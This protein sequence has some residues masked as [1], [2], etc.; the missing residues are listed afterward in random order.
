MP[1][2]SLCIVPH[3]MR[4]VSER[5]RIIGVLSIVL[6]SCVVLG[7]ICGC[8]QLDG[9]NRTRQGNRLFRETQFIDAAAEYQR[10][11]K[12]V[13]DPVIHYNLGLAYS[14]I[15]KPGFDGPIL[16]GTQSDPVCT[17]IPG[18]KMVQAGACVKEGDRHF[19]ECGASKT[20]PIQKQIAE[21]EEK[22]KTEADDAKKKDLESQIRDKQNELGRYICASSF[23]CVEG[24]FCSLRSP[25]IAD[26][27]A[28]HFQGWLKV[29]MGD[30]EIKREQVEADRELEAAKQTGN[31]SQISA[32][33]KRVD[34]L[35]TK[36]QT[37]KIMTKLWSDSEQYD[38][39]IA[40]WESLLPE[41]PNDPEIMYNLA[42]INLSAG[43]WRKAVEWHGKV[44][45]ATKDPSGKVAEYQFIG[46]I[47]WGK[48][49]ARSLIGVD[50]IELADRGLGALQKAAEL[51]P[52]NYKL[53]SLQASLF[54]FR[55]TVHGTSWAAG[56]ER[57]SAQDL[58][59]LTRVLVDKA[60]KAQ[61]GQAPGAPP[62]PTPPVPPTPPA[63]PAS[64]ATGP[65][66]GPATGPATGP[67][68]GGKAEKSGG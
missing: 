21:L 24:M 65:T 55:A 19:A 45:E 54:N 49:N 29:Q 3:A 1:S 60:T 5:S 2:T 52:E 22:R 64:S 66:T 15:F 6:A 41:R 9:R 28:Q 25:E 11:L 36:D 37:R 10:A 57:A 62:A 32:A 34:D 7:G 59:Q 30:D 42:G 53:T 26:L 23:K 47:A 61:Q 8:E 67:T 18:A 58:S 51:Q 43:N 13:D 31:N 56:I 33:Q 35:G 68:M 17:E 38:K 46:N 27:A 20:D 39:A 44:A 48:L 12:E 50:A 40:Y 16:L 63:P 14:K 4:R